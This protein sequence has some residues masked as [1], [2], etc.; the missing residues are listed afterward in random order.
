MKKTVSTFRRHAFVLS[1]ASLCVAPFAMGAAQAA[2]LRVVTLLVPYPAGGLSDSIA[3]AISAA[4]GRALN[5]QVIVDNLG[6]VS[7]S[8]A[9]QKVLNAPA[10][11]HMIFLGSPNEVILSPM[12]NAAVK[13]RAE[14]FRMLGQVAVNPLVLLTRSTLPVRNVD[15]FIAY[16]K[17]QDKGL[18][19]GS[20]GMGSM[21]HLLAESMAQQTQIHVTH[22]PYK[23]MAPMVQDVGG[24]SIDFA[25]LPYATSFKGMS[26]QGRLRLIGWLAPTRSE[27]DTSVPALGESQILKNFSHSTWAG[28]MVSRK[29]PED[30]VVRLNK[31]L[32]EVLRDPEV[33]RQIAATGS[34]A[35][36]P[37]TLAEAERKLREDTVKFRAMA[38]NIQLQPQ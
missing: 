17:T 35:P 32:A 9:A 20:V 27:L 15:E 5:Q 6:G 28:L 18:S 19:Y 36:Q 13:L 21:Y 37:Q 3:R 31:A 33:R 4:L 11:G 38:K 2:D 1:F 12:V 29:T 16:A 25:I 23:G 10:D 26:E 22:V 34:E 8:L 14:D 7:G 24:N 30:M